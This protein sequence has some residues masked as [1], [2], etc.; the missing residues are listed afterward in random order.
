MN[1][2]KQI[3]N[4]HQNAPSV[5][6]LKNTTNT[7]DTFTS[8]RVEHDYFLI[9][10]NLQQ[11][12]QEKTVTELLNQFFQKQ[13]TVREF[14]AEELRHFR[15]LMRGDLVWIMKTVNSNPAFH[16]TSVVLNSKQYNDYLIKQSF[17]MI[18]AIER[19]ITTQFPNLNVLAQNLR[20]SKDFYFLAV[21]VCVIGGGMIPR[22]E[23]VPILEIERNLGNHE[24]MKNVEQTL[25]RGF[26]ITKKSL[27]APVAIDRAV[28]GTAQNIINAYQPFKNA[29]DQHIK[30]MN[31][32]NTL[33]TQQFNLLGVL[34]DNIVDEAKNN[35][36]KFANQH[37]NISMLSENVHM[38]NLW[39]N[40]RQNDSLW[41]AM[42]EY[43]W[44]EKQLQFEKEGKYADISQK[45]T[46]LGAEVNMGE[47]LSYHQKNK[48][49]TPNLK[50]MFKFD[51]VEF[52]VGVGQRVLDTQN[53]STLDAS[54][55]RNS[56]PKCIGICTANNQTVD[57][58]A[59]ND[60]ASIQANIQI[61]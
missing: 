37:M 45:V 20:D 6:R 50:F 30:N 33:L 42:R 35:K 58:S 52:W 14:D 55:V 11:Q 17:R 12:T 23:I 59:A 48:K 46:S 51:Q 56:S 8:S 16:G 61:F 40:V 1:P 28:E 53:G 19:S 38:I 2:V 31:S 29:I 18:K 44:D 3:R 15:N 4:E 49:S 60:F 10:F 24:I 39:P 47:I 5:K 54:V 21:Q 26:I 32:F 43:A 27:R 22:E 9:P 57:G 25:K 7:Q 13:V 34:T 36:R 41:V